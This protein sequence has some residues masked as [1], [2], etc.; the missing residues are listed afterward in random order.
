MSVGF[1]EGSLLVCSCL[2]SE[3]HKLWAFTGFL[4]GDDDDTTSNF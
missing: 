3:W 1:V 2:V 4:D